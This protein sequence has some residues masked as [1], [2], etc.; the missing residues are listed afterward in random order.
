MLTQ[1]LVPCS[2]RSGD[3]SRRTG[4]RCVRSP[5]GVRRLPPPGSSPRHAPGSR[6]PRSAASASRHAQHC[7][8]PCGQGT[9][10][11]GPRPRGRCPDA[12]R[13]RGPPCTGCSAGSP[14]PAGCWPCCR[15]PRC[16]RCSSTARACR[17]RTGRYRRPG[18]CCW[19]RPGPRR[20]DRRRGA[21]AHLRLRPRE[22][23]K[24]G[25]THL[26]L[27]AAKRVASA[28]AGAGELP[29]TAGMRDCW[30]TGPSPVRTARVAAGTA[31]P[32]IAGLVLLAAAAPA[33][34]VFAGFGVSGAAHRRSSG[35]PHAGCSLSAGNPLRWV[36]SDCRTTSP[37]S[38]GKNLRRSRNGPI[39]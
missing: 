31:M 10:G 32:V 17:W 38:D 27:W 21:A 37:L 20:S 33:A 34:V 29:G 25:R 11:T 9:S 6:A 26:R 4:P 30:A 7:A 15:A 35:E 23:R 24:G 19:C 8:V 2:A 12:P 22:Y 39:G 16:S 1:E 36:R 13:R 14:P 28:A 3:G 18:S 5:S